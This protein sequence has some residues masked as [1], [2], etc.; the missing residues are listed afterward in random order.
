M[1]YT[2]FVISIL[3]AGINFTGCKKDKGANTGSTT[4]TTTAFMS[5]KI[6]GIQ[7]SA[8]GDSV[9]Y[10]TTSSSG[11][12]NYLYIYGKAANGRAIKLTL[13]NYPGTGSVL[14]QTGGATGDYYASGFSGS[15]S[16]VVSG[17]V[18]ITSMTP[19]IVGAFTFFPA[20]STIIESGN[21]LVAAL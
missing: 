3:I 6:A 10:S 7:F 13:I 1:K 9:A 2:L 12:I 14:M 8:I 11:G 17:I 15:Y 20:D 18:T 4:T 5:A 16:H 21:F 19:N